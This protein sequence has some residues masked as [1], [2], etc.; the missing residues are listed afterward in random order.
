MTV[1]ARREGRKAWTRDAL[2]STRHEGPEA[3]ALWVTSLNVGLP[4]ENAFGVDAKIKELANIVDGWLSL[5]CGRPPDDL[6]VVGLN[7]IAPPLANKL[8]AE[9]EY[10]GLPV[11]LALHYSNCLVWRPPHIINNVGCLPALPACPAWC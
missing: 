1:T 7:E 11:T 4:D 10:R 3:S 9:L 5:V 8:E 2:A 6:A